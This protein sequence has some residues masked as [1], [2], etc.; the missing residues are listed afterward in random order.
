M[1]QTIVKINITKVK[2]SRVNEV[3]MKNLNFGEVFSDHMLIID[4]TDGKWQTPQI[5]PFGDICFPPSICAIHYGQ[6]IFE[7]LKAFYTKQAKSIYSAR[8][9]TRADEPVGPAPLYPRNG[10]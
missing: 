3:D 7:G 8:R 1:E 4:Y 6:V 9:N 2:K 5:M 10:L